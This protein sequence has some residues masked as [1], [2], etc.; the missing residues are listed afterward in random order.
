[1][2]IIFKKIEASG[3]KRFL[4]ILIKIVCILSFNKNYCIQV[5]YFLNGKCIRKKPFVEYIFKIIFL[6]CK[7]YTNCKG[8]VQYCGVLDKIFNNIIFLI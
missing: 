5:Y 6:L 8:S 2:I 7:T 3:A 1:M 4:S